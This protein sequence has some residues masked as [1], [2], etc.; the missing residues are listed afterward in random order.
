ML[1]DLLTVWFDFIA[2]RS[3]L[4]LSILINN[5]IM[6]IN[7]LYTTRETTNSERCHLSYTVA[8]K[9]IFQ[10]ELLFLSSLPMT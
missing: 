6:Y 4:D 7:R 5:F 2:K 8:Q 1:I 3:I 9:Y 10:N